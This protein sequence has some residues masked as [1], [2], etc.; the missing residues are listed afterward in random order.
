MK[1][2]L[3]NEP[4]NVVKLEIEIPAKE[5]VDG[6]N[7]AVRRISEYVNIPGFRKGKAPRNL[8]E[9]HVGIDRIKQEALDDLLPKAF[10]EAVSKNNLDVISR[11]YVESYDFEIGKDLKIIAKVE[12]RPE[13]KL[14]KYKDLTVEAKEYVTAKDAFDNAL[15]GLLQRHAVFNLVV[16]RPTKDT[17]LAVIDFDG[18]VNG[19]KIQGGAAE[20]Y[21]LDLANSNF[22]PGFAEKLVGKKL[23]EEFE[24]KVDFPKD[25]HDEKLA[26]QPAVF[27]IKIKEIK[28]KVL[29]EL[30]DEFA[31]KIGP[32][33]TVE[34]L[35]ADI[36]KFLDTTKLSEDVKSSSN[37]V[38]QKVLDG[39]NVDIQSTMIERETQSL[40]EEY[41]QRVTS[42]G[43]D[44]EDVMK[45]Q[46]KDTVMKELREEAVA[47]IK[48]SLV[49]DKIAQEEDIKVEPADIERKLTE[50]QTI[51]NISRN[52]MVKQLKENPE[53]FNSLSQQALNE[54][55]IKFLTDNNKVEL[56]K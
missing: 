47:R 1:I 43:Y 3:E 44:F 33:K 37:A 27:K 6:Y 56:K 23:E 40:F 19:E 34:D 45:S 50:V 9:Q 51:Y 24:I 8:V 28:E 36:Q 54:K 20:S 48:N 5:A 17:D 13:V 18:S 49:I 30:T 38:F 53:I 35:K 52:D 39:A 29:P 21:P 2:S 15:N 22:I 55:V 42:Q 16:D 41:K 25:Y 26:G 32:F 31:Q 46:D 10:Q 4:N 11:P 12:L 7:R 14:G